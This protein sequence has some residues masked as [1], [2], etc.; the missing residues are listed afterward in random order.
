[1]V[2]PVSQLG[3]S[4]LEDEKLVKNG[5]GSLTIFIGPTPPAVGLLPNWIPTP[6]TTYY[7]GIYGAGTNVSTTLQVILRS[8]YPTP[9]NQPPSILPYAAG[10]LPES[11][12]PPAIVPVNP[13]CGSQ[14]AGAGSNVVAF[15][16]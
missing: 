11:Y 14:P 15:A 3:S 12:I 2:K 13:S 4:E 1:M 9:G 10:N 16:C 7:D 5:D 8:Y 6:S